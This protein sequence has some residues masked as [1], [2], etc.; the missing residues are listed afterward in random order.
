MS[1]ITLALPLAAAALLTSAV[2]AMAARGDRDRDGMP[3]RW[4]KRHH[5]KVARFDADRDGLAN[6]GEYRAHPDPRKADT[7]RDGLRDGA[8]ARLG[9][10]PRKADSDGDG[11]RDGSERPGAVASFSDGVL[12]LTL[13]DGRVI[14]AKV[15]AA[16]EIDCE[17]VEAPADA[18]VASAARR[19][20]REDEASDDTDEQEQS[21]DPAPA[22]VDNSGPGNAED[23]PAAEDE[24]VEEDEGDPCSAALAPGAIVREAEL[25][26]GDDGL[27]V[28]ELELVVRP[29]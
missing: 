27:V 20:E 1:R 26:L 13:L 7:D 25:E 24:P 11:V 17:V 14:T 28:S 9:T 10:D 12:T 5:V 8:E 21:Q 2:P 29:A 23:R 18:P 4:E 15:T 3:D 19:G 16:T 22:Q 6:V